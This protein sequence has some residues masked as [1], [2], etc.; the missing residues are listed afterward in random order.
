MHSGDA[1][2]LARVEIERLLE[3]R[4]P[5]R[6]SAGLQHRG[7]VDKRVGPHH[8]S[9]GGREDGEALPDERLGFLEP[10][11][12]GACSRSDAPPQGLGLDVVGV[13]QL[14]RRRSE[15]LRVRVPAWAW[16]ASAR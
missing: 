10:P 16:T 13:G 1:V 2:A 9:V 6:H 3:H 4:L 5:F 15:L 8:G 11:L 14:L 7:Q 12:P